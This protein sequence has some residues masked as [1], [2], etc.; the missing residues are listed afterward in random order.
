MI[1]KFSIWL[2]VYVEK[3]FRSF[4]VGQIFAPL[5]NIHACINCN[6]VCLLGLLQLL[7]EYLVSLE[8]KICSKRF[9]TAYWG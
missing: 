6:L 5:V 8:S 3:S 4:V 2:F 7:T 1:F 9:F